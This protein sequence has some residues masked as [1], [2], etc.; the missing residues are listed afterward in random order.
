MEV[1]YPPFKHLKNRLT[2]KKDDK[3]D[4]LF[5]SLSVFDTDNEKWDLSILFYYLADKPHLF[6]IILNHSGFFEANRLIQMFCCLIF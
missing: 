5:E 1:V 3:T 6:H 4:R 2:L